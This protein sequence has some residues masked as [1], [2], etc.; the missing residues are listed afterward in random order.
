MKT[1]IVICALLLSVPHALSDTCM[2]GGTVGGYGDVLVEWC[3]GEATGNAITDFTSCQGRCQLDN[4]KNNQLLSSPCWYA[5]WE[6][7]TQ[8]CRLLSAAPTPSDSASAAHIGPKFCDLD[9]YN[10]YTVGRSE[11]GVDDESLQ[12]TVTECQSRCEFY[13]GCLSFEYY[14]RDT[15][16]YI[17]T[18][19][20][21]LSSPDDRVW[22]FG[23]PTCGT[24]EGDLPPGHGGDSG[25]NGVGLN[26]ITGVA[27]GVVVVGLMMQ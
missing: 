1:A 5:H 2:T 14:P 22:L 26:C 23:P 8:C 12:S 9:Q 27:M 20:P 18:N 21:V 10:C 25:A 13:N 15:R 7:E 3:E 19:A 6:V 4:D 17:K 16:C 24:Y 11:G